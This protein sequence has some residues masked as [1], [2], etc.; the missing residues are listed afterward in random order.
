MIL[1]LCAQEDQLPLS[2]SQH[3]ELIQSM[4]GLEMNGQFQG[5]LIHYYT[6]HWNTWHSFKEW[7]YKTLVYYSS[8]V[9]L[10]SC[11]LTLPSF[12]CKGVCTKDQFSACA[13]CSGGH[14]SMHHIALIVHDLTSAFVCLLSRTLLL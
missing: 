8:G 7:L 10:L 12:L 1:T 9:T 6:V 4:M 13:C 3:L 11:L 5:S 2:R 14:C